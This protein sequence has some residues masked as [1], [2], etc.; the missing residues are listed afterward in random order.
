MTLDFVRWF[1]VSSRLQKKIQALTYLSPQNEH[2][3]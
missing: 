2:K 1:I 3:V